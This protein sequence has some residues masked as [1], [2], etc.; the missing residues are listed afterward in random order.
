V[1]RVGVGIVVVVLGL[2]VGL[3]PVYSEGSVPRI[4]V[5]DVEVIFPDQKP[6]KDNGVILVPISF[7]S[8]QLGADVEW[9]EEDKRAELRKGDKTIN[10]YIGSSDATVNGSVL[11]MVVP[12]RLENART[13]VP[14]LFVVDVFG[15]KLGADEVNN[16]FNI[17]LELVVSRVRPQPRVIVFDS[18]T[19]ILADG[20]MREGKAIEYLNRVLDTLTFYSDSGRYFM[21]YEHHAIP[22]GFVAFPTLVVIERVSGGPLMFT[23]GWTL[24]E[25][26]RLSARASFIRELMITSKDDVKA[27]EIRVGI[28][29]PNLSGIGVHTGSY[30][31]VHIPGGGSFVEFEN[32]VGVRRR[33]GY[34]ARS[35]F[36]WE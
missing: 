24:T 21:R 13:L 27:I 3:V 8:I 20:R 11:G 36:V 26:Q 7:V 29:R 34:N 18:R 35:L 17:D 30:R 19:D 28:G 12:A 32:N 31:L 23:T 16:R 10:V 33:V 25:Y 14:L 5:N 22:D 1:N 2:L 4:Y 6:I 15:A 9:H